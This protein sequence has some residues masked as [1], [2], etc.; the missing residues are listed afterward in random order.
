MEGMVLGGDRAVE[1]VD[2]Q[3]TTANFELYAGLNAANG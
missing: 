1:D 2:R 3:A